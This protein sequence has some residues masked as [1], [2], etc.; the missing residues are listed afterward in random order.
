MEILQQAPSQVSTPDQEETMTIALE[1]NPSTLAQPRPRTFLGRVP[2]GWLGI[3]VVLLV[4]GAF[5]FSRWYPATTESDDNGYYGQ[6]GLILTQHTLV[7][8]PESNTQW[9]GT[10]WLW[11]AE[12]GHFVS[13][14]PPGYPL[15]IAAVEKVFGFRAGAGVNLFFSL[16]GLLGFF[17]L[18]KRFVGSAWALAGAIV[19]CTIP[20]FVHHSLGGYAHMSVLCFLMWGLYFAI[21][22]QEQG[23]L[24]QIFLMGLILGCIPTLRYADTVMGAG[25]LVFLLCHMRRWPQNHHK[26]W[27]HY[28]VGAAGAFLPI[29]ALMLRNKHDLGGFLRTGYNLT[30]EDEAFTWE[31]FKAHAIDYVHQL[32]ANGVGF[33]CALGIAGMVMMMVSRKQW[34]AG[35]MIF[36]Q[37]L[38]MVLIYMAYYWAPQNNVNSTMRFLVPTFPL[39]V[40]GAIY[41]LAQLTKNIP[42]GGRI[43]VG[44]ALVSVHLLWGMPDLW[45]ESEQMSYDKHVLAAITDKLD[46]VAEKGSVVVSGS[47]GGGGGGGGGGS[48][49]AQYLDYVKYWKVADYSLLQGGGGGGGGGGGRGGRGGGPGGGGG[50]AGGGGRGGIGGATSTAPS[51]RQAGKPQVVYPANARGDD[52]VAD[53]R[54]WAGPHKLYFVGTNAEFE[55]LR[56]EAGP[57]EHFSVKGLVTLPEAPN[58]NTN[59][60]A[61]RGGGRGGGGGG[62]GFGGG[63]G[64]PGG[65][66]G[67]PGGGGPGGGGF[68]GQASPASREVLI[69]EW[70]FTSPLPKPTPL[71]ITK[72]PA[73]K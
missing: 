34:R 8:S 65:G 53:A 56:A 6:A 47:F 14:Y 64:G 41:A 58:V 45:D 23:K 26:V 9:I 2:W 68:G 31:Y 15:I 73:Q 11:D 40:L 39:F 70:S 54:N 20:E 36:L 52:F 18:A 32:N 72:K 42:I 55:T 62:G 17:A 24:W 61:G 27:L 48:G 37:S 29:F 4:F 21:R 35:I 43:A 67:G 10:H 66:F 50:F 13:R 5:L 22:W 12:S 71:Q 60:R 51:P 28:A 46:Q 19:L 3:A 57:T 7:F 44:V 16:M 63:A 25:A 38:F 1:N 49:L 59:N 30:N 33:L 69:V